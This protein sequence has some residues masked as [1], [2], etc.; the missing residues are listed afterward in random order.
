MLK[1]AKSAFFSVLW[2]PQ[3][4]ELKLVERRIIWK[5]FGRK[6]L[7]ILIFKNTNYFEG[8]VK[9]VWMDGL[10]EN[11]VFDKRKIS[12]KADNSKRAGKSVVLQGVQTKKRVDWYCHHLAKPEAVQKVSLFHRADHATV[13]KSQFL[14]ANITDWLEAAKQFNT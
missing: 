12:F 13:R 14:S 11:H 8:S 4:E 6:L 5:M 9:H 7:I 10:V 1:Q 2:K 3:G